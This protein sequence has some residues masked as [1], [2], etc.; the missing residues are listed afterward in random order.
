MF[1]YPSYLINEKIYDELHSINDGSWGFYGRYIGRK[2]INTRIPNLDLHDDDLFFKLTYLNYEALIDK[3]MYPFIGKYFEDKKDKIKLNKIIDNLKLVEETEKIIIFRYIDDKY[4][5]DFK[6][7]FV[8]IEYIS[9]I[10]EN[11]KKFNNL[12]NEEYLNG[13]SDRK[14]ILNKR[15]DNS[16]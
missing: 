3:S 11:I 16:W 5:V 12:I 8:D 6:L 15:Y 14:D 2:K 10:D 7:N 1:C 9:N 4:T 13:I